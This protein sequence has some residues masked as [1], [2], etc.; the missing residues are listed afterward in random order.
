MTGIAAPRCCNCFCCRLT[1]ALAECAR[2][3]T[4]S[5]SRS[6]LV[7]VCGTDMAPRALLIDDLRWA[8]IKFLTFCSSCRRTSSCT[9]YLNQKKVSHE[10]P[11]SWKAGTND[12]TKKLTVALVHHVAFSF[13]YSLSTIAVP[14]SF[15][16]SPRYAASQNELET[17]EG[18]R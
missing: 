17:E 6:N 15:P 5:K 11:V 1:L 8:T 3:W 16:R 10:F 4:R 14:Q 18:I 9:L 7:S 2:P 12:G 13:E